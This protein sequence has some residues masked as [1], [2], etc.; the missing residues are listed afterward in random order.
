[1]TVANTGSTFT[2]C[3]ALSESYVINSLNPHHSSEVGGTNLSF[4]MRKEA[5]KI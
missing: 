5:Q 4:Q 2:L 3:Q 1:M